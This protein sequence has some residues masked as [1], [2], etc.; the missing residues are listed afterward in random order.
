MVVNGCIMCLRNGESIKHLFSEYDF[1]TQTWRVLTQ[2]LP[3]QPTN[4]LLLEARIG[5]RE[6]QAKSSIGCLS[7]KVLCHIILW[8]VWNERNVREFEDTVHS[9]QQIV[10]AVKL[11]T[12]KRIRDCDI[13]RGIWF[14]KFLSNWNAIAS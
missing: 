5:G 2:Y 10:D 8:S 7:I 3:G 12:W 14:G 6:L 13:A 11:S 1:F 4:L 9:V